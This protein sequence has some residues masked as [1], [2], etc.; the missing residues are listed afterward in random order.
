MFH[1]ADQSEKALS[2]NIDGL[3]QCCVENK[4]VQAENRCFFFGATITYYSLGLR[5]GSRV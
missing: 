2:Q 5:D 3:G 4:S 1:T